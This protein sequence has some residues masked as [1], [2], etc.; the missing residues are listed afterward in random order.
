MKIRSIHSV[1]ENDVLAKP[2]FNENGDILLN[3]GVPLS[4]KMIDRLKGKGVSYVYIEDPLTKDVNCES[5]IT[6]RVRM[7]SVKT[8]KEKFTEIATN[9]S[10]RKSIL[11][12]DFS[13][14]FST[15]VRTILDNIR[16]NDDAISLLSH[17]YLYDSY[18]FHH[19]LNVTIYAIAL[20]EKIHLSDKQLEQLGLGA[21]LHDIGK[22]AIPI[23]VLNKK[24][25]L[26]A[27]EFKL[28]QEHATIG[29]D[30][31]RKSHTIPLLAAHCAYQHHERLD[32]SG[33]P[34]GLKGDEIH[35][36]AQ[37]IGIADV[38]DA[39]TSHR[40]YRKAKLPHEGLEL[41]YSGADTLF[42]KDLV[43]A[44]SRAVAIYPVG[45]EVVLSNRCKGVVIKQNGEM[46]TRPVVRVFEE[47]GRNVTPY[48]IDLLKKLDVT[49]VECETTLSQEGAS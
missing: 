46:T 26:T 49:I 35:L 34:R 23:E 44:F 6:E 39:V 20:G 25:P 5:V 2:I 3:S 32:G 12:D 36:Y 37:I 48:E 41:L 42:D 22:M 40:V 21:I 31:L 9:Q 24:D 33:Y 19:S 15:I 14:S 47:N 30:I 4:R 13:K 17:V 10:L 28:I 8:I 7:Q 16:E 11:I 27:E 29:F 38:F 43:Q 45:M 18:I 1:A